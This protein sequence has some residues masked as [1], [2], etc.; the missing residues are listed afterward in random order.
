MLLCRSGFSRDLFMGADKN[1]LSLVGASGIWCG[2]NLFIRDRYGPVLPGESRLKLLL[3]GWWRRQGVG[4][5]L[6]AM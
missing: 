5:V 6:A 4:A 1:S 3:Q 2:A